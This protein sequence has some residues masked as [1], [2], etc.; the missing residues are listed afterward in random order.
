MD[1]L[2]RLTV[3]LSRAVITFVIF[4]FSTISFKNLIDPVQAN[5][6]HKIIFGSPE[7]V[8]NGRVGF[9][10]F[11]FGIVL[12]L[13]ACLIS[14]RRHLSG[15]LVVLAVDGA[16]TFTRICGIFADGPAEWTLFVLRPE[17]IILVATLVAFILE[18]RRKE[19]MAISEKR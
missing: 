6:I 9:G 18:H 16:A 17:I 12:I 15:L 4:L 11:P 2:S 14:T 1:T 10:A 19:R 3:W 7:A 8:T 13:C 5:A